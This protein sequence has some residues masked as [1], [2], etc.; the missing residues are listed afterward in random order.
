MDLKTETEKWLTC[1]ENDIKKYY[2]ADQNNDEHKRMLRNIHAYISD[3]RHFMK[4]NDMI[5]AFEAVI[6][7]WAILE[8]LRDLG[9]VKNNIQN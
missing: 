5:R 9:I 6:W 1:I 2:L 7:A 8:T 3:C 4:N